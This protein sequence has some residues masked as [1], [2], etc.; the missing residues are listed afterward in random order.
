MS[1]VLY[2]FV[3]LWLA[4]ILGA[5]VIHKLSAWQ[6]FLAVM[7]AYKAVPEKLLPLVG[8]VVVAIQK[9]GNVIGTI[10]LDAV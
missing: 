5:A 8:G 6:R 2:P 1:A 10:L 4:A 7:A 9:V 3:S